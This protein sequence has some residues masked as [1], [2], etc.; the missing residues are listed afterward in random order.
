MKKAIFVDRDGTILREPADEQIDSF[1]KMEFVAG[2][3]SGLKSLTDLGYEFVMVSNQDGLG[4]DS[5]PE[6]TFYPVQNKMLSILKGEGVVFDNILIDNHFPEDNAPTYK[7]GTGML[8]E[9]MTGEYDLASCFVIGDRESDRQLAENLGAK[10]F[11]IDPEDEAAS[12]MNAVK[13]IRGASRRVEISRKT[14]ETD[15]NIVLDLDGNEESVVDTGLKFLDH[16]ISQLPGHGGFSLNLTCKGDL[17]VDE[18]HT[19]E[20]I[21]IALG[22]AFGKALGDKRGIARY[23]FALPMDE[24]RAI[25]LLDF[26]G[27]SELVWDVTFTREYVGDVP[28]EMFRHFFKSFSDSAKCNIYVK[29]E[30]ENNHH[31]IESVFKA[32]ARSLRQ[33]IA[34]D[35]FKYE[36]SSTKGVL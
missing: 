25:V 20:D 4:T 2:A 1:E 33:A 26:G 35:V 9:Y 24:S 31:I 30:G 32:F 36:L 8:T 7:P 28:T 17:E 15:I 29:S 10:F 11:R 34:R 14:K 13:G 5:F 16:M 18:H 6:E 21:G 22:E 27:R 12:W 3:I 23:G 19:I